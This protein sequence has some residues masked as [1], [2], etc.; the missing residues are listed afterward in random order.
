MIKPLNLMIHF[1]WVRVQIRHLTM[2]T[3][4]VQYVRLA[5][6]YLQFIYATRNLWNCPFHELHSTTLLQRIYSTFSFLISSNFIWILDG[7]PLH[8]WLQRRIEQNICKC[9]VKYFFFIY[10]ICFGAAICSKCSLNDVNCNHMIHPHFERINKSICTTGWLAVSLV[11]IACLGEAKT[12][13]LEAL[14]WHFSSNLSRW[15][16]TD[17]CPFKCL[18]QSTLFVSV[19]QSSRVY[20]SLTMVDRYSPSLNNHR[21]AYCWSANSFYHRFHI[22]HLIRSAHFITSV[23]LA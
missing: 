23:T 1:S 16:S 13:S 12:S 7:C 17:S 19:I 11:P 20:R 3:K 10:T 8:Y 21:V 2:L 22:I 5:P 18:A 14:S 15:K 4:N 6:G 9:I